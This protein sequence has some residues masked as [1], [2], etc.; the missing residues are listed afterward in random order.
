LVSALQ[1]PVDALKEID[2]RV[3][4]IPLI[5]GEAAALSRVTMSCAM[6]SADKIVK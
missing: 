6:A 5:V 3:K 2:P 4:R 1:P